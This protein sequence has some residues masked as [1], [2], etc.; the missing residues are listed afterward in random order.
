MKESQNIDI[1]T[2][3]LFGRF[4]YYKISKSYEFEIRMDFFLNKF[5]RVKKFVSSYW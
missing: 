1:S 4:C 5:D 2:L 3:Y